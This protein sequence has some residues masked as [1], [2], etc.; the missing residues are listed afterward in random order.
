MNILE[1]NIEAMNRKI[2][3]KYTIWLV[4]YLERGTTHAYL[5]DKYLSTLPCEKKTIYYDNGKCKMTGAKC[6]GSF[7]K[8][9]PICKKCRPSKFKSNQP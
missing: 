9:S 2:L 6:E 4:K 8:A 7:L 5:V 3:I 1:G